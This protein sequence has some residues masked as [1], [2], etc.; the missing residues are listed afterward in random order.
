MGASVLSPWQYSM[1]LRSIAAA[2]LAEDSAPNRGGAAPS[3]PRNPEFEEKHPRGNTRTGHKGQFRKSEKTLA[4]LD[5]AD[6]SLGSAP[7]PQGDG[8]RYAAANARARV[9]AQKVLDSINGT[10]LG[11]AMARDFRENGSASL[12]GQEVRS[13]ADLAALASVFSNPSFETMRYFLVKDGKVVFQT[14]VTS[15]MPGATSAMA[16]KVR[17]ADGKFFNVTTG[18]MRN[19]AA[20]TGADGF[21]MLHNHP[22]GDIKPSGQDTGLTKDIAER[23][24][25]G[26]PFLGHIVIDHDKFA[27]IDRDGN[28]SEHDIEGAEAQQDS[29][30]ELPNLCLGAEC[31][32]ASQVAVIGAAIMRGLEKGT[33]CIISMAG[34]RVRGLASVPVKDLF[35]LDDEALNARMR[36]FCMASTGYAC[37]LVLNGDSPDKERIEKLITQRTFV[38]VV[39]TSR[40]SEK[41]P[42][43]T[44]YRAEGAEPDTENLLM[45]NTNR[46][47]GRGNEVGT[48]FPD[49]AL[50]RSYRDW[51]A[52]EHLVDPQKTQDAKPMNLKKIAFL[53]HAEDAAIKTEHRFKAGDS[54][55]LPIKHW[56]KPLPGEMGDVID[57]DEKKGVYLVD[58]D[59]TGIADPIPF[60]CLDEY[61][62]RYIDGNPE[63]ERKAGPGRLF[64]I[65]EL[66]E[67]GYT[68]NKKKDSGEYD[69]YKD[70]D[71][72]L[73]EWGAIRE[74]NRIRNAVAAKPKDSVV[75]DEEFVEL[76]KPFHEAAK[77]YIA[78]KGFSPDKK[79]VK[80]TVLSVPKAFANAFDTLSDGEGVSREHFLDVLTVEA[81]CALATKAV[82]S[83]RDI[84]DYYRGHKFKR[85]SDGNV[86]F[87]APDFETPVTV[88]DASDSV[89]MLLTS[90][91]HTTDLDTLD[92]KD[93]RIVVIAG[94]IMGGGMDSDDAGR[95]YLERKFFPWCR[96]HADKE[97][98][99]TAGNHD[100]F[101]FRQ[102][103][104]GK[105]LNWP[106]NVHYL[107]DKGETIGGLKFY[108]TPWC[109]KNRPGRF[110]GTEETL[111]EY[112]A[113]MPKNL[114]VLIS[115]S[116]PYI[117]GEKIDDRGDG[118]HEGSKELTEAILDKKPRLVVCGHVHS[119][120]RKP[121]FLGDSKVMNVSRVDHD[122]SEEA[123]RPHIIHFKAKK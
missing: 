45:F 116:P 98:V 112:F 99:V 33:A 11:S 18:M 106:E 114:D 101:L 66:R 42:G 35:A 41:F 28:V 111:K 59:E 32:T 119:G 105:K 56:P 27:E 13:P 95:E 63:E 14:G 30:A 86:L 22:S 52:S 100:K 34:F 123:H 21:Y 3:A 5:E 104:K 107:V 84:E 47:G 40:P 12:L 20:N 43:F 87:H 102:W 88:E 8:S 4:K 103:V 57:I 78:D 83:V 94:D 7:P 120:S 36:D 31:K 121:A 96:D 19:I 65:E 67:N 1:N 48:V 122:R 92:P 71:Q 15:R 117:P 74:I 76:N 70:F 39:D 17:T 109:L 46:R 2:V 108:G 54:V 38:D 44:S 89:D 26:V 69:I 6:A 81:I 97:I 85:D 29:E 24:P 25:F 73:F 93:A 118:L 53:A 64:S 80:E 115:H 9:R 62:I 10:V 50:E 55:Q 79:W 60:D 37:H 49:K 91:L 77:K 68:R 16:F 113:K 82:D 23:N 51:V 75:T 90:D 72:N 58:F 61:G 110:E